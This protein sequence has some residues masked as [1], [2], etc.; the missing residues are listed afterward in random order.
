MTQ[1]TLNDAVIAAPARPASLATLKAICRK[2]GAGSQEDPFLLS[3]Y[4]YRPITIYFTW[5]SVKLGLSAN[6]VT[7]VSAIAIFAAAVCF[8]FPQPWMWLV[9]AGLAMLYVILDHVDGEVARYE[10]THLHRTTGMAGVFYDT[11]VHPGENAMA[12][13]IAMRLYV[14]LGQPWWLLVLAVLM[15][16]PGTIGPWQRYCEA[17][18]AYAG[19][20]AARADGVWMPAQMLRTS[21]ATVSGSDA[22]AA[23]PLHRKA[24]HLARQMAGWS[25]QQLWLPICTLLDVLP[26]VPHLVVGEFVTPYLLLWLILRSVTSAVA[27]FR[28]TLVYGRRLRTLT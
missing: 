19:R 28:S 20:Q 24:I 12:V 7:L 15:L 11:A 17:V 13:A 22:F 1:T 21:S 8:G 6:G 5:L 27:G 16:F 25:G 23:A 3:R 26:G 14:D 9:G 18:V 10:R 4:L 2:G